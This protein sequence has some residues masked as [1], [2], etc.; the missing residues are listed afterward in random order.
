MDDGL[1]RRAGD[2]RH[3]GVTGAFRNHFSSA[4]PGEGFDPDS[5]AM[6]QSGVL[7]PSYQSGSIQL[8]DGAVM[9]YV[10]VGTGERRL[11]MVPGAGD[12]LQTVKD[13]AAQLAWTYRH[14]AQ[15]YTTLFVSR[16]IPLPQGHAVEQHAQDYLETLDQL[17]WDEFLLE[18]N[19]AGG[20]IG[21]V[22]AATSPGRVQGL[23]L[24][25]TA[26]RFDDDGAAR[27]IKQW[28][29]WLKTDRMGEFTWDTMVKTYRLAGRV[30]WLKPLAVP[31]LGV[32]ARPRYGK[33]RIINLLEELLQRDTSEY[34]Q[35]INCPTMIFA[36][37]QDP[38]LGPEL[39]AEMAALIQN[40]ELYLVDGYLHGADL[41]S[42]EY[43]THQSS[44]CPCTRSGRARGP[45]TT[46][47][48][49]AG[50]RNR[51]GVRHPGTTP[52][53]CR[54]KDRWHHLHSGSTHQL[55]NRDGLRWDVRSAS[56]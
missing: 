14:R 3:G 56:A 11:V 27:V 35:Q 53:R 9:P 19:S 18:C 55:R 17:G 51:H 32:L 29:Q 40:S 47:R 10:R 25:S 42:P 6:P 31:L 46:R 54:S 1:A 5:R 30:N 12:G 4:Y 34:L 37:A 20:P 41:E 43:L 39:Q 50:V 49:Q 16:R 15:G 23:V 21:Q 26:H 8:T 7:L 22:I 44:A 2:G 13:A 36:G 38:I 52:A 28:L 33:E 48:C 45:R 24:G